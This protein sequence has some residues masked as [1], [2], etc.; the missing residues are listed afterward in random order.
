MKKSL[1]A[2]TFTALALSAMAIPSIMTRYSASAESK[3]NSSQMAPAASVAAQDLFSAELNTGMVMPTKTAYALNANN[4]LF[5]L[6]PGD[7]GFSRLTPIR[8]A[9]G[10]VIGIDV[11]PSDG[12]LYALT[13][14]GTVYTIA[15]GA[16][17]LGA[18]TKVSSVSPRFD[19]GYQSLMDFNP[20][21]D[22]LRLIGSN[23]KNYALVN[24][25]GGSLNATAV[26]TAL[27]YPVGDVNAGQDANIACGSYT[28]NVA[29]A[30]VTLFYA[31]DHDKDQFVTIKP[32]AAGGSSATGGGVLTTIGNLV[33]PTGARINFSS[34]ADCDIITNPDGT[35]TVFGVN[36]RTLFSIS[37]AQLK[38]TL[39][40]GQT[41]NVVVRG[42]NADLNSAGGGFCDVAFR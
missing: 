7:T 42:V 18:A 1:A 28:N 20:V 31:I 34:T 11:R 4:V 41:Q 33:T 5:I 38:T 14:R 13:D 12:K 30:A 22:A 24:S 16:A 29:G 6:R 17:N 35:N 32:A 3:L 39:L 23:R 9:D 40:Q 37:L 2:L 36:G 10:N 8:G 27:T 19:A 26:Q 21:V 25:N 15:L